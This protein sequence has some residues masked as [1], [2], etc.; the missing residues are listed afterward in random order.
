MT[1]NAPERSPKTAMLEATNYAREHLA[2]CAVELIRQQD[3]GDAIGA[4][5]STL[6]ECL[7]GLGTF[8]RRL[9]IAES[10]IHRLA[11]ESLAKPA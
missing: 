9:L 8:A 1:V 4:R 7:D 10:I 3:V 2:E 5:L 11:L 6:V